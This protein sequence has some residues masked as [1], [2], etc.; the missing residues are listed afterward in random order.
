MEGKKERKREVFYVSTNVWNES[1][2]GYSK[3][4]FT[5][6][7]YCSNIE[8]E[9]F[10]SMSRIARSC[11]ISRRT[12]IRAI[13]TL[14]EKGLI[15]TRR[16]TNADREKI[17]NLY[18]LNVGVFEGGKPK[19]AKPKEAPPEAEAWTADT[20]LEE[21]LERLNAGNYYDAEFSAAAEDAIRY[22]WTAPSMRFD[23]RE[24][25][26]AEVRQRLRELDIYCLD[27]LYDELGKRELEHP[28]AYIKACL[29]HAPVEQRA[30]TAMHK[31]SAERITE[32]ARK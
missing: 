20:E 3:L 19:K 13:D 12:V 23:G 25:P 15:V 31:R 16:R 17:T 28:S 21:L 30:R 8:G 11:G 6:L 18:R 1:I 22:M 2:S 14:T 24:I 9:S 7:S 10:P 26:Q 32:W 29:Y 4:V 5:Y 27:D